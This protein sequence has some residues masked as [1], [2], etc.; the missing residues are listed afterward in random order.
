MTGFD[1]IGFFASVWTLCYPAVVL[2]NA[3]FSQF[4]TKW[5]FISTKRFARLHNENI[6]LR[7]ELSE[8]NEALEAI[9][10]AHDEAT[11]AL[12]YRRKTG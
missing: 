12:A 6:E 4:N 5:M 8:K 2:G 7:S 1:I 9:Q 3:L 10:L 11:K